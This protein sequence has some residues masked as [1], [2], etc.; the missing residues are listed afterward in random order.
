MEHGI[1]Y[2]AISPK[3]EISK[4]G[5]MLPVYSIQ[6]I[7]KKDKLLKIEFIKNKDNKV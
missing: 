4:M 2:K 5:E 7:R 1:R 6:A 3:F